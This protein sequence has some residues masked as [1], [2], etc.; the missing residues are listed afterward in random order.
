MFLFHSH[1]MFPEGICLALL[2]EFDK[3]LNYEPYSVLPLVRLCEVDAQVANGLVE[4]SFASQSAMTSLAERMLRRIADQ[5]GEGKQVITRPGLLGVHA[6]DGD[7][8]P[9]LS[10]P[11]NASR[12]ALTN[13]T[14]DK[15]VKV[16]D[17][18]YKE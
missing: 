12:L 9:V 3:V 14:N 15:G 16:S 1:R 8:V 5:P 17:I 10:R 13:A 4:S 18:K 11:I 6:V 7:G 2:E